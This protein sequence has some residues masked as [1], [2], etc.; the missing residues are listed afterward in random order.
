M[1]GRYWRFYW[2]LSLTGLALLVARQF[3]NGVLARYPRAAE[4]ITA[5]AYALCAFSL[6]RATL[7][8]V[9][10]MSNRMARS[11]ASKGVCLRFTLTVSLALTVPVVLLGFTDWG[12][13]VIAAVFGIRGDMLHGVVLYLRL[14]SPLVVLTGLRQFYS[15]LLIQIAR[16]GVVTVMTVVH[17]LTSVAVLVLGL[18]QDWAPALTLAGS[19]LAAAGVSVVLLWVS[20]RAFWRA[21]QPSAQDTATY[22]DMASYFAPVALTSAMFALSRPILYAFL[23]REP[24]STATIAALKIAFDLALVFHNPLNQFRS[25]YVTFG[26]EHRRELRRFVMYV[27]A[28]MSGLMLVM[29]AT[30]FAGL[31]LHRLL[32]VE[33]EVLVMARQTFWVLCLVPFVISMRNMVHG[34]AL[35]NRTTGCMSAGAIA[36]NVAIYSA[37]M[38]LF[39]AGWLNHMTGAAVLVLGFAS[40]AAVAGA[41][42][43]WLRRR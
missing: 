25:L 2:P 8:F 29:A 18:R 33:G 38:L 37:A 11:A 34:V 17:L 26:A 14:L 9:P 32:G 41:W 27:M 28:A 42:L 16:T 30:P 13:A 43:R 5:Y 10:H 19:Q 3:Q 15:G 21:P 39:A 36:R 1:L 40:E 23:S 31:V 4:Q 35:A 7:V 6:F 20:Y 12:A 22:R 24:G